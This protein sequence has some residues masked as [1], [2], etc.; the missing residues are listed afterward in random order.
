MPTVKQEKTHFR[1]LRPTFRR[2]ILETER[3]QYL[4][5]E[6]QNYQHYCHSKKKGLNN[7]TLFSKAFNSAIVKIKYNVQVCSAITSLPSTCYRATPGTLRFSPV[8][9]WHE[10]PR[11]TTWSGSEIT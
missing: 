7:E 10:V 2:C 9:F 5:N 1:H 4:R 6:D 11:Q 8:A 3:T